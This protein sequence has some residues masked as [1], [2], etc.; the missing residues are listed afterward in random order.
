VQKK[1]AFNGSQALPEFGIR[2]L[3]GCIYVCFVQEGAALWRASLF[4]WV[5]IILAKGLSGYKSFPLRHFKKLP[6]FKVG[7]LKKPHEKIGL[8]PVN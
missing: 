4:L 3:F 1:G 8:D 7:Y 5:I 2:G 6:I